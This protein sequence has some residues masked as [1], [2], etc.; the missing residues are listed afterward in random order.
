MRGKT[1]DILK[2]ANDKGQ[3][4]GAFNTFDMEFTQGIV[5]AVKQVNGSCVI[6]VTPSSI[7]YAGAQTIGSVV[8]AIIDNE[9]GDIPIGFHLDHGKTFEDVVIGIEMGMDSV[10][11][12]A[13]AESLEKNI[14]ITKRVVE[15]AHERGVTVQAELGRVP[16]V[17]RDG[18]TT[19]WEDVMT[20]PEEAKRLIEETGADVLAVGIGNAHGFFK[21]REVPDWKRLE[22]IRKLIPNVPL[23]M[24]GASDWDKNKVKEAVTRGIACFNVD[25]DLR[26]AFIN[27]TC[28]HIFPKCDLTDPRKA[29]TLAR[30][31]VKDKVVEKIEMF[32]N[33]IL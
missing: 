21:E 31:A 26:L 20:D 27:A 19:N 23:V 13:S 2:K 28:S 3:A 1:I 24:H 14:D 7:K 11:I 8:Q 22:K 12:D 10:M 16:Y 33:A 25:T 6:Q 18:Q 32:K 17:G 30:E 5:G 15:Y 29:L 4:V 9:S